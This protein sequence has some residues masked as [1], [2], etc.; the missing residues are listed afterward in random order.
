MNEAVAAEERAKVVGTEMMR[1]PAPLEREGCPYG[2]MSTWT[3]LYSAYQ[4]RFIPNT[5]DC[6]V[7]EAKY[8]FPARRKLYAMAQSSY[9]GLWTYFLDPSAKVDPLDP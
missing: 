7:L 5:T 9:R 1:L 3:T 6:R 4:A 2:M 8:A